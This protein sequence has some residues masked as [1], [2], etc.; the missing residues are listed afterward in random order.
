MTPRRGSVV[1]DRAYAFEPP[2]SGL[3]IT[4]WEENMTQTHAECVGCRICSCICRPCSR[5]SRTEYYL[6]L[7]K[8]GKK[9]KVLVDIKDL[10]PLIAEI[11]K[12][13]FANER[14]RDW[15]PLNDMYSAPL[16]SEG[17]TDR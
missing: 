9:H 17:R 8:S 11:V 5:K 2:P 7:K 15:R 4:I 3:S 16:N 14:E 1:T 12:Q 10:G 13:T 6:V